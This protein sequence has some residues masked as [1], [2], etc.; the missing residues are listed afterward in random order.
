MRNYIS[1]AALILLSLYAWAAQAIG[2]HIG[3]DNYISYL[4]DVTS[5]ESAS[6]EVSHYDFSVATEQAN[7]ESLPVHEYQ[8][9]NVAMPIVYISCPLIARS[10]GY[11]RCPERPPSLKQCKRRAPAQVNVALAVICKGNSEDVLSL[12]QAKVPEL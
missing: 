10:P 6:I 8:D 2:Q 12:I 5:I 1:A 3:I 11:T 4:P 9:I 7:D